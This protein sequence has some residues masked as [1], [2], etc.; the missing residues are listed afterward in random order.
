M[1]FPLPVI[2]IYTLT[3]S[4]AGEGEVNAFPNEVQYEEGTEVI[5]QALS[6]EG[7]GRVQWQGSLT[8]SENPLTLEMDSNM[9][10]EAVFQETLA[11]QA[12]H[13]LHEINIFPVPADITLFFALQLR[14]IRNRI[15][16]SICRAR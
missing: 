16:L 5:L 3:T 2:H 1:E 10:M 7:W 15:K 4:T 6:G 11:H 8:S 13:D 9:M 12:I 14:K